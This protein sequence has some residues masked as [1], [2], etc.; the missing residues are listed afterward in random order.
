MTLS[1]FELS[2]KVA[3]VTGAL[4]KLG[5]VWIDALL[6]AGAK[7]AGVDLER[8]TAGKRF[9]A[10][11]QAVGPERLR[12]IRGD[13]TQRSSL[14]AVLREC[15]TELGEPCILVNNA[16]IDQPPGRAD[17]D[18]LDHIPLEKVRDVFDVNVGGTFLATQVFGGAMAARGH[19]SVVNIGS[20]YASLSPDPRLYD[21]LPVDPPFLKPPAYGASKAAV[22]NLTRYFAVHWASCGVRVNA[23]SPG[24]VTGGQD[25]QFVSKFSS[26]VPFRRLACD[27]DLGGPLIFLASDASSYVTG[28]ELKVDGGY[29][30]W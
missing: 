6:E 8:A 13:V 12:L 4:G 30:S 16:G 9:V 3:V 15:R 25:P 24:G 20:I 26:R 29:S 1:S 28:I 14:E 21:H 11:M 18:L 22:L 27:N 7:V 23:L 5:P 19:G 17:T 10:L 2:D